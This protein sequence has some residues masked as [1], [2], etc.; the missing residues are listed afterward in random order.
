[1]L[2]LP[3]F[4][5]PW[6]RKRRSITE[7]DVVMLPSKAHFSEFAKR[8]YTKMSKTHDKITKI[9]KLYNVQKWVIFC[10]KIPTNTRSALWFGEQDFE[11]TA[12]RNK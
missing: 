4:L 2:S 3:F 10:F 11:C 12:E 7:G 1:V 9:N 5:L 6:I 8:E